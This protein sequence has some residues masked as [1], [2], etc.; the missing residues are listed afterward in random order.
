MTTQQMLDERYGRGRSRASRWVIG[1]VI[2]LAALVA[3]LLAWTMISGS[4]DDVVADT[5]GYSIEGPRAVE[6]RFQV[7]A[8]P[9]REVACALEAQD[10]D[11]GVVGWRIVEIAASAERTRSFSE[12]IPTVAEG[13]TGLVHS[14]WVT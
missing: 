14:C 13:T 2:A 1:V 6:V 9:D 11:H 3:G 10:V 4:L 5:T 12:T 8:P 7:S